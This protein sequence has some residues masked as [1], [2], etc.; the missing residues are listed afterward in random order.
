MK[1]YLNELSDL[2]EEEIENHGITAILE[3]DG[4]VMIPRSI[5]IP[6]ELHD[7]IKNA[8]LEIKAEENIFEDEETKGCDQFHAER[9]NEL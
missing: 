5:P 7:R 3:E 1:N 4:D 6:N 2:F 8:I 9:D